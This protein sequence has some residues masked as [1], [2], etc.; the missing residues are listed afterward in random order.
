MTEP[1]KELLKQVYSIVDAFR[2]MIRGEIQEQTGTL[3]M[4]GAFQGLESAVGMLGQLIDEP[5]YERLSI[6]VPETRAMLSDAAVGVQLAG[7]NAV[8]ESELQEACLSLESCLYAILNM[9]WGPDTPADKSVEKVLS[10][11]EYGLEIITGLENAGRESF[12]P[13]LLNKSG[14]N[15]YDRLPDIR[16]AFEKLRPRYDPEKNG[17]TDNA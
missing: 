16:R 4:D 3:Y 1:E 5:A 10:A 11:S 6:S 15:L 7:A 2:N 8:D 13:M 12:T 17:G 14:D 9:T